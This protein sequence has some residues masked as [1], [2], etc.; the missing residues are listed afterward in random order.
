VIVSV[1]FPFRLVFIRFGRCDMQV[2]EEEEEEEE[3]EMNTGSGNPCIDRLSTDIQT[4]DKRLSS[5]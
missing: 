4:N 5:K 3:R 2:N 1:S